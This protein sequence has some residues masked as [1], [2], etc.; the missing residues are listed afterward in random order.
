[1]VL[2]VRRLSAVLLCAGLVAGNGAVC[3]GW[4]STPEARMACCV[5]DDCPMHKGESGESVSPHILTQAEAD[6]CC[7]AS[8]RKQSDTSSPTVVVSVAAPAL[9]TTIVV[10]ARIPSRVLSDWWRTE[11]PSL[12]PPVPRHILL[13]VF[14][15]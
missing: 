13:S 6:A 15:V 11:A 3:A 1:M 10:P 5:D 9:G 8:E 14:L 4:L 7:A 2:F 12:I